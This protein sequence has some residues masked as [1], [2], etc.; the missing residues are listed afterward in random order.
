[1]KILSLLAFGL[2]LTIPS[3]SAQYF[4]L[5]QLFECPG[6]EIITAGESCP[7]IPCCCPGPAVQ[8][9]IPGMNLRNEATEPQRGGIIVRKPEEV[10]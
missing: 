6:G 5:P 10:S 2:F 7:N 4:P 9:D 1:M 3:A 8:V